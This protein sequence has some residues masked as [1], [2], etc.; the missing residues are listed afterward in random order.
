GAAAA[1]VGHGAGTR[2][3]AAAGR[4]CIVHGTDRDLARARALRGRASQ[5][6]PPYPP[7]PRFPDYR[8]HH[9]VAGALPRSGA[10]AH[11]APAPAVVPVPA[12]HSD[13]GNGRVDL[14]I[15]FSALSVL[16]RRAARLGLV[17]ARGSTDWRLRS[18]ER[19][20]GKGG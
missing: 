6:Q 16:R 10:A 1:E 14:A 17:A 3:D 11:S 12:R 15:G 18:E 4:G 9:V 20:V 13:V 8:G 5:S 19:R 7:A 2:G